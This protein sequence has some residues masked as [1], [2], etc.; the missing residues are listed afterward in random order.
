MLDHM[1]TYL[2]E[3]KVAESNLSEQE[4]RI[5]DEMKDSY[6]KSANE[7]AAVTALEHE[8]RVDALDDEVDLRA[9]AALRAEQVLHL[10]I[11]PRAQTQYDPGPGVVELV[12]PL[13]A[14]HL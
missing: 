11:V 9:H 6:V 10:R 3:S 7:R 14:V 13:L 5:W 1:K 8:Q 12:L 2:L 4:R